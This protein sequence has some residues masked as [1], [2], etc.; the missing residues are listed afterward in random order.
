VAEFP[1][2]E[3]RIA[4]LPPL[5]RGLHLAGPLVHAERL[6]A[7]WRSDGPVPLSEVFRLLDADM[8]AGAILRTLA[9]SE[10]GYPDPRHWRFPVSRHCCRDCGRVRGRRSWPAL[11]WSR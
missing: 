11:C 4:Q 6:F 3:L 2:L 8:V 1:E 5:S 10:D 7:L 9:A